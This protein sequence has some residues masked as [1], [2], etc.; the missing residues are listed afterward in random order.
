MT[1]SLDEHRLGTLR[2]IVLTGPDR[3][4]FR[5]LGEHVRGELTTLAQAWPALPRLRHHVS[6]LPG[7]DRLAAVRRATAA[8]C[9][10]EWAELTAFAEGAAVP[11]DDLALLNFRGDLGLVEGGIGCSDLAWCRE[12]SV[13]AH[14]EDGGPEDVGRCGLLTLAAEGRPPV[15]AFWYPGFLPANAFAV[16]GDGLVWTIDHLPVAAPGD[17]AGRHFVGRALQRSARTVDAAIDCLRTKPSAGGFAYTIGDRTGRVVNVEAAAGCHAVVTAGAESGPL[18]WHTNHGRYISGAEPSSRG[19]SVAR[20]EVLDALAVPAADPGPAWFLSVL[21]GA[22][23]PDG[24]RAEPGPD[25]RATTLCTFVADL[26]AGEAVIAAR[27]EDPIAIPLQDLAE[28]NP[29]AQHVLAQLHPRASPLAELSPDQVGE[30]GG[31]DHFGGG[32][33]FR[34]RPPV[35][36]RDPVR[37]VHGLHLTQTAL[38]LLHPPEEEP[39]VLPDGLVRVLHGQCPLVHLIAQ[40][41][42]GPTGLLGQFPPGPGRVVL[43]VVQPAARGAP[44]PP[45]GQFVVVPEQQHPVIRIKHDHPSGPPQPQRNCALGSCTGLLHK[46]YCPGSFPRLAPSMGLILGSERHCCQP[47]PRCLRRWPTPGDA[48]HTD[49]VARMLSRSELMVASTALGS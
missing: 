47:R 33:H 9:G 25:S 17:G 31:P 38:S 29:T 30:S 21:A 13:I 16:T 22:P 23:L 24:V 45:V 15:T 34:Q 40:R 44:V 48:G 11:L 20:G 4:A 32:V 36:R 43:A 2:W 19:T 7:R 6:G 27:D 49:T 35:P 3:A 8:R 12:R 28:G 5:A 18:L 42:I 46:H 37:G 39:L 14:N 10:P 26:T 1:V 41:H